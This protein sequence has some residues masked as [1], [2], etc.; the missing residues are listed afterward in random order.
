M[1]RVDM[2][3]EKIGRLT[4]LRLALPEERPNTLNTGAYWYC[5]CDCGN[6]V[7]VSREHLRTKHTISCGC[8]RKEQAKIN[9]QKRAPDLSGKTFGLLKVIERVEGQDYNKN[10]KRAYWKCQC[11]CGKQTI[12]SSSDLLRGRNRSCGCHQHKSYGEAKVQLLLKENGIVFEREKQFEYQN[13]KIRFD[14]FVEN[15]YFIEYDGIQHY[16]ENNPW[17][18]PEADILKNNFC[19]EFHYPLIRIPYTIYFRLG[20]NDLLIQTSNF[21]VKGGDLVNGEA[22]A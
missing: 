4:V 1:K 18:R 15:Q 22:T 10:E 19:Q 11:D 6:T 8:L 3:G 17:H 7:I 5:Q 2:T 13:H 14:F 9:G 21:L 20:I 16:D 12:L